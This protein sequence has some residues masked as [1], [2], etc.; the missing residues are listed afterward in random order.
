MKL[1][2]SQSL[3]LRAFE[4]LVPGAVSIYVCGPTVQSAP[5]VGHL[6]SALVYDLW[7][8]WFSYRGYAVTLI[9]NV[10][11][12]DD[13]ILEACH[14]SAIQWWELAEAVQADFQDAADACNAAAEKLK[15]ST[16]ETSKDA[17]VQTLISESERLASASKRAVSFVRMKEKDQRKAMEMLDTDAG[18]KTLKRIEAPMFDLE[19]RG[20]PAL[21][22][23]GDQVW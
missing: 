6:R 10:T 20:V 14:D 8:R 5:H 13:K 18:L 4:P 9:R 1:F 15:T 17:D 11:D 21:K 16:D 3:E 7:S 22:Y 23:F 2:D 19:I 12:I